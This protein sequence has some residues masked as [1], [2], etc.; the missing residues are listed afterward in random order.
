M[1][2][3]TLVIG[4]VGANDVV[5]AVVDLVGAAVVGAA[6]VGAARVCAFFVVVGGDG[7]V[8]LGGAGNASK[9]STVSKMG[10]VFHGMST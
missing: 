7:G 2:G 1:L 6:V 3:G 4:G 5:V 10:T 9:I 8:G